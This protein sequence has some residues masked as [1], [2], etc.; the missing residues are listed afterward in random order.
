VLRI[1]L[2]QIKRTRLQCISATVG[3]QSFINL[4]SNYK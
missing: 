3:L 2:Q 1:E 4:C